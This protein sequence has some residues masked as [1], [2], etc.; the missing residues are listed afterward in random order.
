MTFTKITG[1]QEKYV[2]D[3]GFDIV[4]DYKLSSFSGDPS[5]YCKV[6]GGIVHIKTFYE[7]MKS[8]KSISE[9]TKPPSPKKCI[10]RKRKPRPQLT[11]ILEKL[12]EAVED[13][14]TPRVKIEAAALRKEVE[15]YMRENKDKKMDDLIKYL[16]LLYRQD[17]TGY[18]HII[19]SCKWPNVRRVAFL[20]W[21]DKLDP[22][23]GGD[24]KMAFRIPSGIKYVDGDY[25]GGILQ[26]GDWGDI[27]I[28]FQSEILEIV[29]EK[30]IEQMKEYTSD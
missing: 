29:R 12:T 6:P 13:L 21:M 23:Y 10:R 3:G 17:L 11:E 27:S 7:E 9:L 28:D 8:D 19:K 22:E 25:A 16:E 24:F 14:R 26:M 18:M 15:K 30:V 1:D 20:T 5:M 4:D 2:I